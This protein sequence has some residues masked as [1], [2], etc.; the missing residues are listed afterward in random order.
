MSPM[1]H[2][3]HSA[4]PVD[5]A[6]VDNAIHRAESLAAAGP[7]SRLADEVAAELVGHLAALIAQAE[8]RLARIPQR[9]PAQRRAR[10][11][12]DDSIRHSR[13]VHADQEADRFSNPVARLYLLAGACRLMK[14]GMVPP[15]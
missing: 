3:P 15:W 5:L 12:L 14:S 6:L 8:Y 9:T 4:D 13:S 1:T 11:V 2:N 10:D 7:C